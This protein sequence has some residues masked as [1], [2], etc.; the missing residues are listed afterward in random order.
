MSRLPGGVFVGVVT[1][2]AGLGF[3]QFELATRGTDPVEEPLSA[4]TDIE[5]QERKE[6]KKIPVEPPQKIAS[7]ERAKS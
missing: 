2:L 6:N 7:D 3:A 4:K 1:L 5:N